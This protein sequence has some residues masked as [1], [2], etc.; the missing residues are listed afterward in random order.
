MNKKRLRLLLFIL[1]ILLQFTVSKF[2]AEYRINIDFMYIILLYFLI[3]KQFVT[4]IIAAMVIGWATDYFAGTLLGIFGFSRVAI[5]FILF[6]VFDY[7]DPKKLLWTF[8]LV[9]ISLL[10]SNLIAN[11]FMIFIYN[12]NF[13]YG[14]LFIQPLLTASFA[15][16]ILTSRSV[17]KVLNVH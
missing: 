12:F 8:S 16:V 2:F 5:A 6:G 13:D 15:T 9:F 11:L 1:L 4:V 17:R 3:R 14:L 7:I 10:L